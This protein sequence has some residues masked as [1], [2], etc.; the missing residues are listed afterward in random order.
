M[1]SSTPYVLCGVGGGGLG[2]M[3]K[4]VMSGGSLGSRLVRHLPM[5]STKE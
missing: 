4:E 2:G 1:V 3:H 5:V